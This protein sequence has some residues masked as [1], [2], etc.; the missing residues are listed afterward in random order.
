[1]GALRAAEAETIAA[2]TGVGPIRAEAL[3]QFLDN[4][5]NGALI[6]DLAALGVRMDTEAARRDDTLAGMTL[7]LT[8]GLE[9][10]TRDEAKQAVEDR[11]GKVTSSVSK[12]T[13]AV[14]AGSDA[15]SKAARAEE[16]GVPLLDEA[17]FLALLETGALPHTASAS[18]EG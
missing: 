4:P 5:R 13:S 7:V 12:K 1:M 8:G 14:V 18:R 15:G 2:V 9:R 17:G 10:F 6:D 11:G 3:R 16:L